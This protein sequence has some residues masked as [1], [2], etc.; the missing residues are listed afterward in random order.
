[1]VKRQAASRQV[2]ARSNANQRSKVNA[3]RNAARVLIVDRSD[4]NREVLRT[5]LLRHGCEIFE[6]QQQRDGL[7]LAR[8]CAAGVLVLDSDTVDVDDRSVYAGFDAEAQSKN[9]TIILL[10][11]CSRAPMPG[12]AADVVSKPYHYGPLIRK[13]EQLLFEADE[14]S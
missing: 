4:D 3:L 8:E 10:G 12:P 9:A 13:I 5:A 11:R 7:R 1:M 2:E 14:T 6:A